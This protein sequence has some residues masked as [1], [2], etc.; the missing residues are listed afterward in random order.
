MNAITRKDKFPLPR[1]DSLLDRLHGAKYFS[2][3]D[4]AQGYYQIRMEEA[5]IPKTAFRTQYGFW[6]WVVLPMG[7]SNAPATFQ[8]AMN[9]M[10]RPYLDRFVLVYLD[11]ILIFSRSAEE[12]LDHLRTVL[13]TLRDNKFFAKGKKCEFFMKEIM[14]LGFLVGNDSVKPDPKKLEA[15]KSWPPLS[16]VSDVRRFMGLANQYRK[17]IPYFADLAAP[18]TNLMR[19]SSAFLWTPECQK[20]FDELKTALTSQPCLLLPDFSKPFVLTCDA[21]DFAVGAVLEQDQGQGWQPVAYMSK[22]LYDAATRYPTHEKE[23]LAVYEALTLCEHYLLGSPFTVRVCTDH[24]PLQH[25]QTQPRMSGRVARW[26]ELLSRFDFTITY[27]PGKANLVADALSRRVWL[28]ALSTSSLSQTGQ[29]SS[30]SVGDE[31]IEELNGAMLGDPGYQSLRQDVEAGLLPDFYIQGDR[32]HRAPEPGRSQLVI[33]DVAKVKQALLYEAHDTRVSGHLGVAKTY[34]RI[35]EHFWWPRM[36][37][38][39]RDYVLSCPECQASKASNAKAAGLLHPLDLPSHPW[40]SVSLDIMCGLEPTSAPDKFDSIAVFVCRLTK[41]IRIAPMRLATKAPEFAQLFIN[42]VFRSHGMPVE[43][44]SDR[45][46]RFVSR[47]WTSLFAALGTKLCRSSTYHPETNGQTKKMNRSVAQ[48]LRTHVAEHQK[49]WAEVLPLVEFAYNSSVHAG[50]KFS[51][52]YLNQGYEPRIPVAFVNSRRAKSKNPAVGKRLKAIQSA[53]RSAT[54]SLSE[55]RAATEKKVNKARR[56]VE[57]KVGHQV[58]LATK[59]L[60]LPTHFSRKLSPLYVGPFEVVKVVVPGRTVKL[61]LPPALGKLHPTFHVSRLR[62][63]R[64]SSYFPRAAA[65]R[66]AALLEE[67]EGSAWYACEVL[68]HDPPRGRRRQFRYL[69][70]W[71]GY[72][73]FESEWKLAK[74]V[75]PSAIEAYWRG[76]G[77]AVPHS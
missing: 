67:P 39:T 57:Y 19:Q 61:Q 55:A 43:L 10:F 12:H 52:F 36:Y 71:Q 66:P 53:L 48:I 24:R 63:W 15:I 64:T 30:V 22:K 3:V 28:A 2:K 6:E 1:I 9:D 72:D 8:R 14:F 32:L 11:D 16:C 5:D 77:E 35:Q 33:P 41:M 20:A 23:L 37:E 65:P 49:S 75:T 42:T 31:F 44:V 38:E 51:P 74:E 58:L 50:S 59:N 4:L 7:L 60:D 54:Q 34:K 13:Q 62:P 25:V 46:P 26:L 73:D 68:N 21:S 76:R 45:D 40:E 56:A 29:V 27:L 18:L 69:V 70:R 47:F 17:Y